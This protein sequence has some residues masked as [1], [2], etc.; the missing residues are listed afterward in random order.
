M[1]KGATRALDC[2]VSVPKVLKIGKNTL[3]YAMLLLHPLEA[4]LQGGCSEEQLKLNMVPIKM[5]KSC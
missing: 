5:N 2:C 3:I 4:H 1:L